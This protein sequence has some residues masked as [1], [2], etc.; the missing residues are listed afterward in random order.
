MA[1]MPSNSLHDHLPHQLHHEQFAQQLPSS[2]A[3]MSTSFMSPNSGVPGQFDSQLPGQHQ[4]LQ[5]L[6]RHDPAWMM[7]GQLAAAVQEQEEQQSAVA[8]QQASAALQRPGLT[9]DMQ[10]LLAAHQ[11]N[12]LAGSLQSAQQQQQSSQEF[13]SQQQQQ[14]QLLLAAAAGLQDSLHTSSGLQGLQQQQH[15]VPSSGELA[16]SVSPVG[17]NKRLPFPSAAHFGLPAVPC[18]L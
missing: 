6:A 1:A 10:L 9:E 3:S 13:W 17:I 12:L 2:F 14:Q 5:T 16:S 15:A 4:S 7:E 18:R 11:H 8:W